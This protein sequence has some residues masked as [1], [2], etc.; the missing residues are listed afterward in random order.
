MW[1]GGGEEVELL[2]YI[3]LRVAAAKHGL[4]LQFMAVIDVP[5]FQ[6]TCDG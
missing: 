3:E 4:V 1:G 2:K 6:C 5:N